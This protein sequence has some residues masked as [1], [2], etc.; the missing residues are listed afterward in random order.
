[1]DLTMFDLTSFGQPD[2]SYWYFQ[3]TGTS[4]GVQNLAAGST[5]VLYSFTLPSSWICAGCVEIL[6]SDIPGLP[7]STTSFIDNAG[8]GVDVLQLAVNNAPLPVNFISFVAQKK[9]QQV[10]LSWRVSNEENLRGYY[11]ERS[12]DGV[13]YTQ[14]GF[15]A[16]KP[17]AAFNDY[18]FTDVSPLDNINYYRIRQ[19]DIDGRSANSVI[20]TIRMQEGGF[21]VSLYP[22]PVKNML[23]LKLNTSNNGPAS[24]RITDML[25][26]IVLQR[27][28]LL[29]AGNNIQQIPVHGFVN[30]MY[31]ID[32][33]GAGHQ[34]TGKFVK[35]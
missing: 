14:L 29:N 13:S 32:I 2:D 23:T 1:M 31:F 15:V 11:V 12:S 3:V 35:E 17:A 21:V 10:Q 22:V 18:A 16:P 27:R 25:G 4:G 33:T 7:I 8:M 24:I 6:T 30:G 19:E 34:W 20:R 9:E 5:T 28:V 26:R